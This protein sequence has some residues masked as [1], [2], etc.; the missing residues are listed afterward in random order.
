MKQKVHI[1]FMNTVIGSK[2]GLEGPCLL[3]F[4]VKTW[5]SV[6]SIPIPLRSSGLTVLFPKGGD[7]CRVTRLRILGNSTSTLSLHL[8][9]PLIESCLAQCHISSNLAHIE[10]T[11]NFIVWQT[12]WSTW[13]NQGHLNTLVIPQLSVRQSKLQGPLRKWILPYAHPSS[14]PSVS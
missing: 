11:M 12:L 8:S 1:A 4:S 7:I 14:D 9:Y 3:L 13:Y 6:F 5:R 2:G 10:C